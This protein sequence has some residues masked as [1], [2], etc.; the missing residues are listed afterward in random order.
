MIHREGQFKNGKMEL[1]YQCWLPEGKPRGVVAIDHGV[2]EHSSRYPHVV[3]ALVKQ[4][5]AVYGYDKRGHGR[6]AGKR[7]HILRWEEYRSDISA[8]L[9]LIRKE[10]PG[11]PIFLYGHSLGSLTTLDFIMHYPEAVK[12]AIISGTAIEPVGVAKP[13]LI[14]LAKMLS[15]VLPGYTIQSSLDPSGLTRDEAACKAYVND[16]LVHT[17]M[18]TRF[19]TEGL[20]T[21]AWIKSHPEKVIIPVLFVH[22]G[23][24]PVNTLAGAQSFFEGVASVDKIFKVYPGSLHEVH[25]DL[26]HAV[27]MADVI[28]WLEGHLP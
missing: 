23:A 17:K 8:Y 15:A 21:V 19:G 26:D 16:P 2:G 20:R 18:T 10:Q 13:S 5:W 7:G 22:G 28:A 12:G 25:N 3:D 14:R 4:G 11:L 1:F 9:D 6:S 24:D 27:L